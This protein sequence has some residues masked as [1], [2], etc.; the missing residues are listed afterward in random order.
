MTLVF[1]SS[2][3]IVMSA[4]LVGYFDSIIFMLAIASVVLVTRGRIWWAGGLLAIAIFIHEGALL[5]GLP[6]VCLAWWLTNT[7]RAGRSEE[8][9]S[10]LPL[11]LPLAAFA[12][13]T[14]QQTFF[15]APDFDQALVRHLLSI[16]IF[17]AKFALRMG[18]A[19]RPPYAD[20]DTLHQPFLVE[21]FTSIFMYGLVMPSTLALLGFAVDRFRIRVLSAASIALFVVCLL[22]Q[23]MHFVAWDTTRIW[24]NTIG[25]AFLAVW[26]YS[27]IVVADGVVAQSVRLVGLAALAFNVIALTPLMD[28]QVDRF[29]NVAVRALLFAPTIVGAI[30]L[31]ANRD[32]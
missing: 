17:P 14:I 13:L 22:P 30:V 11:L 10:Y 9:L 3:F 18:R 12:A 21:R 7:Q 25:V 27:E 29:E 24:V 26:V 4:H 8:R 19:L 20:Y 5:I 16:E 31:L 6:I 2:P 15:V 28:D 1:L 23:T 32:E